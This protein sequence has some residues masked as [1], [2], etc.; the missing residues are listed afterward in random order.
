MKIRHPFRSQ[1][2]AR[3]EI[4]A[5]TH[6]PFWP[7]PNAKLARRPFWRTLAAALL[8]T[9]GLLNAFAAPAPERPNNDDPAG[10]AKF[11]RMQQ[12]GEDG[13][14]PPNALMDAV[15]HKRRMPVKP[16]AWS[17]FAPTGRARDGIGPDVAGIDR[18]VWAWQGPGNIGGRIRSLIIHPTNPAIMWAGSVGGGIWKTM[19]GGARWDP[20][21]D[22]VANIAVASMVIDPTNPNILY[23][24]TGEGF[25]NSDALA[26][27]GIFK[28][29]DGGI[30]WAQLSAT[31][32]SLFEYVN[33]L[34]IS[35][36]NSQ[37][38]LAATGSGI[39][40]TTDGGASWTKVFSLSM[41]DVR[42]HPTAGNLAVAGGYGFGAYSS[43]G[44]VTW[45]L[46]NGLPSGG[47]RARIEVA[48]ART[49]PSIVYASVDN[50]GG[51]I[52]RSDDSGHTYT[53]RN[54]GQKFLGQGFY[55]NAIWVNPVN[56]DVLVVGGVDLW[57]STNGGNNL[58]QI[59]QWYSK[60]ASPHADH[61][62]IVHHPGYDGV[63]NRIVFFGNDGGVYRTNDVANVMP[64]SGWTVL[65]NNL[66]ITQF[67]G[68][69]GHAGSGKIAGGTQDN[70]H[71]V[72]LP[73][74][75]EWKEVFGGDGGWA[76][77]DPAN[78]NY[79]YGE[80]VFLKIE[81][82]TNGGSI[83][84]SNFRDDF[85]SGE[86]WTG[87]AVAWKPDP[88]KIRDAETENANF[89]SPFVLDPND[90]NRILGGGA[91]LWR[92]NEAK[93]PNV[94]TT[95][96]SWQAIKAPAPGL[97]NFISAIA[98]AP[99]RP[100]TIWVGHNGGETYF[101]TNG[102][103]AN[104]TWT[105]ANQGLPRVHCHRLTIDPN[106]PSKVYATFGGFQPGNVW[107]TLD[108]GANWTNISNGL[109]AAPVR[110]LVVSPVDGNALYIGT[111]VGIFASADGGA[112]WSPS[113]DGPANVS[114][115]ELFWMGT[116]LVAA[117]HGRG[118]FIA[119]L[120]GTGAN[121]TLTVQANPPAGGS[122]SGGGSFPIGSSHQISATANGG[123]TFAGWN[124]GVSESVRTVT[125]PAGGVTYTA[126]F[127]AA[128][129]TS[130]DSFASAQSLSGNSG[131]ANANNAD[132]TKEPGEP[133]HGGNAGG[134]SLWFKWTAPVGGA[135]T[136]DTFGSNFDTV[137]G[138]Y[139]GSNVGGL[140]SIGQNDDAPGRGQ[141]S[142]VTFD[143][144]AGAEYFIAVD[145]YDGASGSIVLN[146]NTQAGNPN[147]VLTVLAEPPQAGTVTGGGTFPA[148][149]FQQISA[150][151]N[152]GWSFTGWSDSVPDRTRTVNVPAEGAT[153]TAN[154]VSAPQSNNDAFASAQVI[155]GPSGT[156]T[157]NNAGATKEAGEP[158]HAGNPGGKSIWF[159][160][161][162]PS[163]GAVIFDTFTSDFD[164]LLGVYTGTAPSSLTLVT[165][166]DDSNGVLQSRVTFTATAGVVYYF[167]I[168]GYDG[169]SGSATLNW[170]PGAPTRLANISTRLRVETG[171][172]VLIAGFIITGTQPKKVL[173][174]AVG[175][176]LPIPGALSDPVLGLFNS[177]GELID[178]ND[179]W[180]DASARQDI[181]NTTIPPNNGLESAI[182]QSLA[183]GFY[184]AI[185]IG[186]DNA[187]GIGLVEAYDLDSTADS[188]L[189][190]ISTR[191]LVQTGDNVLI[192]GFI[193]TGTSPQRVMLRGIGPSLALAGQLEDPTLQLRDSNGTLLAENDDW[194]VSDQVE[195]IIGTTIPPSNDLESAIVRTLVPGAYTAILRGF[196][197]S[198]GIAVV[199]AYGLN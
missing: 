25:N 8:V 19:N 5:T 124:D 176:S 114:V 100:D 120:G 192:A 179:D 95:G 18:S 154:F 86:Y 177:A 47:G 67:H 195:E 22:F 170:R 117:T 153:Y 54:T 37:T 93:R 58:T 102:T 21:T 180:S 189:A 162:A 45:T 129:G 103:S 28:T 13:K 136:F 160:W 38:L 172:N 59:S 115:D 140:T 150:T 29:T 87:S 197:D 53:L 63:N 39:H 191:G 134:K 10:A 178:V 101:T 16:E 96:P 30:T 48:F 188:R 60:P 56:P 190:N 79:V 108:N 23:A 155:S 113:N 119:T 61:H 97:G 186:F 156:I 168:D 199:E 164:T 99:G 196:E 27:A 26:G 145:G 15:R 116:K 112:S 12:L 193:M 74:G 46:A 68:A 50:N 126:N 133:N 14:I 44:G 88:Y 152:P 147:A 135:V 92:T 104:P 167:A 91:S 143:A 151:A 49:N 184:T 73:G 3:C 157:G 198:T 130:N 76:A 98:V 148:G 77:I 109:P 142:S 166:G 71:L 174:R 183:P 66:G 52:Y 4:P 31:A 146:W 33:R 84:S 105:L 35:P 81:R 128:G 169:E 90:S 55:D 34:A 159:K 2:S 149:S 171:N 51:E 42:F 163:N 6:S 65:N 94:G 127:I 110:T 123:F 32:V 89:I 161:T 78:P 118:I 131:T 137:L 194:Q 185:V 121:A 75:T 43:D 1:A 64:L 24:G 122:V 20:L 80:Y 70:G 158:N 83:Q 82:N 107:R 7:G 173:V 62:V 11:R 9:F 57:R 41:L 138:I 17:S 69:A 125:V 36:A 85:I 165:S 106:N 72:N 144:A 187:T 181:I 111:E 141:Q 139:T 40:R 182:V 132:A 175:P